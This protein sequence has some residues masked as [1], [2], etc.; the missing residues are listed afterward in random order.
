VGGGAG[1][2]AAPNLAV[3]ARSNENSRSVRIALA[4]RGEWLLARITAQA[5]SPA[6]LLLSRQSHDGEE[7]PN[8]ALC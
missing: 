8:G 5:F 2:S 4:R 3:A 1:S 6:R 7:H